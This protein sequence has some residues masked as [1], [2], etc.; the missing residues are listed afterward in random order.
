MRT[1][2][3][4]VGIVGLAVVAAGLVGA[5]QV[6]AQTVEPVTDLQAV[7]GDVALLSTLQRLHVTQAQ[8]NQAADLLDTCA[9]ARERARVEEERLLAEHAD[10]LR[11]VRATLL[12]GNALN[13]EVEGAFG[14]LEQKLRAARAQ[15][16]KATAECGRALE[17]LIGPEQLARAAEAQRAARGAKVDARAHAK[18]PVEL[19]TVLRQWTD[20]EYATKKTGIVDRVAGKEAAPEAKEKVAALLDEARG[21]GNAD[22]D[23]RKQ[24]LGAEIVA[25]RAPT[26]KPEGQAAEDP[27]GP[28]P[29]GPAAPRA[30]KPDGK[31]GA[32]QDAGRLA[33]LGAVRKM[34]D[35]AYQRRRG[36]IL[37]RLFEKAGVETPDAATTERLGALLDKVRVT[38]EAELRGAAAGMMAELREIL[39][40]LAAR[41]R[42]GAGAPERLAARG[43]AFPGGGLAR[44]LMTGDVSNVAAL[45]RQYAQ[46]APTE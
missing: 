1:R 46:N 13:P 41:E 24:A 45:L 29:G 36:E 22:F 35:A 8:A 43:A 28:P 26:A 31:P 27:F 17:G 18:D 42:E 23:A 19:L 39:P 6:H 7:A 40:N 2:T 30:G 3:M 44:L 38:P 12:A 14:Q 15:G 11:T 37:D 10:L 33:V 32:G 21:L 34:D 25:L 9:E 5:L 20:E 4:L 16:L